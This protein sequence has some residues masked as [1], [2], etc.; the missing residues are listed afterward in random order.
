M[1]AS[2]ASDNLTEEPE[3]EDDHH[4]STSPGFKFTKISYIT[5]YIFHHFSHKRTIYS[6]WKNFLCD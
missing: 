2:L 3:D 1:M 6:R 4:K 5:G